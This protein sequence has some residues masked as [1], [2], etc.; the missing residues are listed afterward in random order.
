MVAN[1]IGGSDTLTGRNVKQAVSKKK[2]VAPPLCPR[3]RIL[4]SEFWTNELFVAKLLPSKNP[5][6]DFPLS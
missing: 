2:R 4:R 5:V 3:P 6:A 1:G